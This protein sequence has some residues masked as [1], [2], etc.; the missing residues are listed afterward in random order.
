MRKCVGYSRQMGVEQLPDPQFVARIDDRPKQTD[1]DGLDFELAHRIDDR[2]DGSVVD[3]APLGAVRQDTTR[4][5]ERERPRDV[6]IGKRNGEI[7]GL[8][9]PAFAQD[10]DVAVPLGRQEGCLGSPSG[11]DRIDGVGGAVDEQAAAA[12]HGRERHVELSGRPAKAVEHAAHG[13]VRR[14]RRLEHVEVAFV[15]LDDQVCKGPPG[16]DG[17]AHLVL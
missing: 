10:E 3:G 9:P 15:I 13:I 11:D 12:Q 17:K 8:R 16:I 14:R 5:F 1:C 2:Q 7:E 4:N 6:G